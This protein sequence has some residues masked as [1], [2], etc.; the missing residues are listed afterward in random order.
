MSSARVKFTTSAD[1]YDGS[2]TLVQKVF[3]IHSDRFLDNSI[4]S[5]CVCHFYCSLILADSLYNLLQEWKQTV[6]TV[7]LKNNY[8]SLLRPY[9]WMDQL[10]CHFKKSQIKKVLNCSKI[11]L[12]E[13]NS[14]DH[15]RQFLALFSTESFI[16][17]N[18][19]SFFRPHSVP[20]FSMT[21]SYHF[22]KKKLI[23]IS[24]N[25]LSKVC[26]NCW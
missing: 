18:S 21:F 8:L 9:S 7:C 11:S 10:K 24:L 17:I 2:W 23:A 1:N 25:T 3:N 19:I 16:Y 6:T 4:H 14:S 15:Y 12:N 22:I 26:C 20:C 5:F 13:N